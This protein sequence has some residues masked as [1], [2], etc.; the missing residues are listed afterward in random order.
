MNI[1]DRIEVDGLYWIK[2]TT[3]S[4]NTADTYALMLAA[5]NLFNAYGQAIS[6][7][8]DHPNE[9]THTYENSYVRS[10][11]NTWYKTRK[12]EIPT[13]EQ[14]ATVA[15]GLDG[16]YSSP[17]GGLAKDA[18]TDD[19][20]LFALSYSEAAFTTDASMYGYTNFTS[21]LRNGKF[22]VAY[23]QIV[24]TAKS[25]TVLTNFYST[26]YYRPAVWV[27]ANPNY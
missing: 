20:V 24:N 15:V 6:T 26:L 27:I 5:T 4:A 11:F 14:Y 3:K 19:D 13:I 1:G 9:T 21:W 25:T 2:I 22:S 8:Y 12:A 16:E 23:A 10:T 7:S 18:N 17:K